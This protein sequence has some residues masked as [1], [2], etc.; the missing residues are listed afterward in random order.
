MKKIFGIVLAVLFCM[1][2][3]SA[4]AEG[5]EGADATDAPEVIATAQ[6]EASPTAPDTIVISPVQSD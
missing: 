3:L 1:M 2:P 5:E 6:P 4:L